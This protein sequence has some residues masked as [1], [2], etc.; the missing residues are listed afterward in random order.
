MREEKEKSPDTTPGFFNNTLK[1]LVEVALASTKSE[2]HRS[3]FWLVTSCGYNGGKASSAPYPLDI[4]TPVTG[5]VRRAIEQR[6]ASNRC[7]F[8]LGEKVRMRGSF[9]LTLKT[10]PYGFSAASFTL[11]KRGQ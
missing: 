8:S 7:S 9:K 11:I 5:F 1:F 2:Y 4:E 10:H 6:D 3:R